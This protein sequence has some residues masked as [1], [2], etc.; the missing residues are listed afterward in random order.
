M[1]TTPEGFNCLEYFDGVSLEQAI[2]IIEKIYP[3]SIHGRD[4]WIAQPVEGDERFG[5]VFIAE[6]KVKKQSVITREA[7]AAAYQ[8]YKN[9]ESFPVVK[10]EQE[11]ATEREAADLR[12]NM[13]SLAKTP[14]LLREIIINN[15]DK[16]TLPEGALEKMQAEEASIKPLR[17]KL[18]KVTKRR[19][20]LAARRKQ[21]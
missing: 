16:L 8:E 4:Y 21:W 2:Y 11:K 1:K 20:A 17:E 7:M 19:E 9:D 3:N 10:S 14:Q 6:W 5:S 18:A 15:A 12:Y 13:E